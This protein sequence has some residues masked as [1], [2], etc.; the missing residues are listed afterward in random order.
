MNVKAARAGLKS[1]WLDDGS[2]GGPHTRDFLSMMQQGDEKLYVYDHRADGA[3]EGKYEFDVSVAE[4]EHEEAMGALRGFAKELRDNL[5]RRFPLNDLKVLAAMDVFDASAMPEAGS[6]ELETYGDKQ[7][8]ALL[9]EFG[10]VKYGKDAEANTTEHPAIINDNLKHE[11]KILKRHMTEQGWCKGGLG[12]SDEDIFEKILTSDYCKQHCK[13]CLWLIEVKLIQFLETA[14]CERMFSYRTQIKTAQRSSMGPTLLD[15]CM[16]IFCLGPELHQ[17]GEIDS[18]VCAAIM[19]YK[20]AR[21]RF[22]QKSNGGHRSKRRPELR[23]ARAVLAGVDDAVWNDDIDE[24]EE[25]EGMVDDV[26]S[27]V[28]LPSPLIVDEEQAERDAEE[29]LTARLKKVG[30]FKLPAAYAG[31]RIDVSL[32][33]DSLPDLNARWKVLKGKMVACK[34]VDGW[35]IGN[36]WKKGTG[37]YKG[38]LWVSYGRNQS[39]SGHDFNPEDYGKDKLWICLTKPK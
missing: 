3:K 1:A 22:P 26:S 2:T 6:P 12:L 9:E 27:G 32:G 38:M 13:Q 35:K 36:V 10:T 21:N 19:R 8:Q 29:E 7:M 16:R 4:G 5:K 24:S 37:R 31:F 33:P 23:D 39:A 28:S 15:I 30:D 34:F 20:A 17:K 18:L 11:W 25:E 14:V